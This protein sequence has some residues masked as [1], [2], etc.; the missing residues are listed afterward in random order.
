MWILGED[1]AVSPN[2]LS[3]CGPDTSSRRKLPVAVDAGLRPEAGLRQRAVRG[4]PHTVVL[5]GSAQRAPR[6]CPGHTLAR[7]A[8]LQA[9]QRLLF[10]ESHPQL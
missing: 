10:C 9:P 5:I 7:A 4:A 1:Q 2:P 3:S 6:A 8:H